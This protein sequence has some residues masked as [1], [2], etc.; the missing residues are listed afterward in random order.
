MMLLYDEGRVLNKEI[1]FLRRMG[2]VLSEMKK[3]S[4]SREIAEE[5]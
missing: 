2:N 5:S 3:C 4:A 1:Y